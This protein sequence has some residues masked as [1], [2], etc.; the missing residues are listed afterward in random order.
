MGRKLKY[1]EPTEVLRIRIPKSKYE[2]FR[3]MALEYL[4][5]FMPKKEKIE[6]EQ[7]KEV[8]KDSYNILGINR[9]ASE[10][11]IKIAYKQL[12]KQYHPDLNKNP[13]AQE[14]FIELNNAYTELTKQEPPTITDLM[15]AIFGK[16]F[17]GWRVNQD[18]F[19]N[20]E[21]FR[22]KS[23][24]TEDYLG[25]SWNSEEYKLYSWA[26]NKMKLLEKLNNKVLWNLRGDHYRF[27]KEPELIPIVLSGI[28][29]I[30]RHF[31]RIL[32]N[33]VDIK[34]KIPQPINLIKDKTKRTYIPF[35]QKLLYDLRNQFHP[36]FI[37]K[38][39]EKYQSFIYEKIR[40]MIIKLEEEL[41]NFSNQ[42]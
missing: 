13:E 39:P 26:S 22:K 10:Q 38:F 33:E 21:E 6:K 20:K 29:D 8:I 34:E 16:D 3:K 2:E 18:D 40:K 19:F 31:E 35:Y 41:K 32:N 36:K 42:E 25:K 24:N 23:I 27:E 5:K 14:R 17:F 28:K 7:Q 11:E 4:E 1:G 37:N 9:N 15:E 30:I 12:A